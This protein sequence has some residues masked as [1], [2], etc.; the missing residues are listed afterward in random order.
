MKKV[1]IPWLLLILKSRIQ[2]N[3]LKEYIHYVWY[4]VNCTVI[5]QKICRWRS[6]S[7]QCSFFNC[8]SCTCYTKYKCTFFRKNRL[9][10]YHLRLLAIAFSVFMRLGLGS[11]NSQFSSNW[12]TM[13]LLPRCQNL[14][15]ITDQGQM[16][17][18]LNFLGDCTKGIQNPN[19]FSY[20][21]MYFCSLV[22]LILIFRLLKKL[23]IQNLQGCLCLSESIFC[24]D[25][26]LQNVQLLGKRK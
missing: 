26:C 25:F 10:F 5:M 18:K 3:I 20:I 19:N 17:L 2:C 23:P 21:S 1:A 22:I 24:I 13:N 8:S 14:V 4:C 11:T 6:F 16:Q 9:Y 7:K 15:W 12:M